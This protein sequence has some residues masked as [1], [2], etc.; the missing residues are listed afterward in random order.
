MAE[1]ATPLQLTLA[2]LE[3]VAL[4][5][6]HIAGQLQH[7]DVLLLEGDLGAGKTTLTQ[8]IAASLGVPGDQYVSS[9]SFS[10]LHEY[11]GRI[12][13]FHM[14]FYRLC[15]EDDIEGSGLLDYIGQ[16]GVCIIE[17]PDRLGYLC[18]K[19]YLE[20]KIKVHSNEI[21]SIT[22]CPHGHDWHER[23]V[24]ICLGYAG[25]HGQG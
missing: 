10:L 18:P 23:A 4:L 8:H 13:V 24:T 21:R 11:S 16:H 20:L 7:G 17:W 3:D 2:N 5:A 22:L 6:R 9:P 19:K 14:D 1:P 12:P 25:E 15:D